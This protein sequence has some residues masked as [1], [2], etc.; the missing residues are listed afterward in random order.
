LY[1]SQTL[2]HI[3]FSIKVPLPLSMQAGKVYQQATFRK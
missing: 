2:V 3:L 1:K